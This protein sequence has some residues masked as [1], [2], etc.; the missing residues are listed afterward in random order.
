MGFARLCPDGR[1]RR[2]QACTGDPN[3]C[4]GLFWPRVREEDKVWIRTAIKLRTDGLPAELAI[5]ESDARVARFKAEQ[6]EREAA[7]ANA[8]ALA[9]EIDPEAALELLPAEP[10][11]G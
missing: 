10:K 3:R 4:F 8:A 5:K 6:A 1:C 9:T 2:V 11:E 7:A